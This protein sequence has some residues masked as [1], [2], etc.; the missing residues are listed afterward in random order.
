M[1]ARRRRWPGGTAGRAGSTIAL[2]VPLVFA[3]EPVRET[4][5]WGQV[6]L[7][8]VA[9]VLADVRALQ[10]HRRWA[11][12]GIGLATAIKADPRPVRRL[13]AC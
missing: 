9:L 11:G 2:A 3:M 10:R 6:N 13:P 12:V 8:L 7:F 1:V 5:G 4:L